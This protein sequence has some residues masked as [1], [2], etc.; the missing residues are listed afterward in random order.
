LSTYKPRTKRIEVVFSNADE[1]TE[2]MTNYKQ[3]SDKV[4]DPVSYQSFYG[5]DVGHEAQIQLVSATLTVVRRVNC[6]NLAVFLTDKSKRSTHECL[7]TAYPR[8]TLPNG[9]PSQSRS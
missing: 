1:Y 6:G 9:S 3:P 2:L 4:F 5:D 8:T 7:N